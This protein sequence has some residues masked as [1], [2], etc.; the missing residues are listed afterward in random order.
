M[1]LSPELADIIATLAPTFALAQSEHAT[2]NEHVPCPYCGVM[3][4]QVA[5][6]HPGTRTSAEGTP[7]LLNERP[8]A[9]GR[10][11][12]TEPG[13]VIWCAGID[14]TDDWPLPR[15]TSH[16]RDCVELIARRE[17]QREERAEQLRWAKEERKRDRERKQERI[18]R[19]NARWE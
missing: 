15:Y 7:L 5:A 4:W 3:V 16:L 8:S 10:W 11:L 2:P 18:S 17:R 1:T 9:W 19:S 6:K 12:M 14:L 13:V